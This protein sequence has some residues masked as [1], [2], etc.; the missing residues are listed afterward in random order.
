MKS[1]ARFSACVVFAGLLCFAPYALGQGS[2]S[3]NAAGA[4]N[5]VLNYAP[6]SF[7]TF[8]LGPGGDHRV[9]GRNDNSGCSNQGAGRGSL[10]LG[11]GA[12]DGSGGCTS[13]PEGGTAAIY[14][15]L[16][17]LCCLAAIL[18]RSRRQTGVRQTN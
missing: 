12:W 14:L 15:S 2:V 17:G 16:A 5:S 1:V 13:V 8:V 18:W 7:L 4:G 9:R 10:A 11:N 3:N 6:A